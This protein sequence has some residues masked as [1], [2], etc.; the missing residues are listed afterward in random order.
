MLC[1][2]QDVVCPLCIVHR[3]TTLLKL[4]EERKKLVEAI[5]TTF[6]NLGSGIADLLADKSKLG[7]ALAGFTLL[8]LGIY[9]TKEG[10]RVAGSTFDRWFGTPSL[11]SAIP[12]L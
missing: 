4:E 7:T 3:R 8:A 2:S 1:A 6:G 11:V 10:V 5:N 9:S 12:V